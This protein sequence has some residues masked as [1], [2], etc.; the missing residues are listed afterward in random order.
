MPCKHRPKIN[1]FR[2]MR[3][4]Y[5][6]INIRVADTKKN[7]ISTLVSNIWSRMLLITC[8]AILFINNVTEWK[9]IIVLSI[10]YLTLDFGEA[11][12]ST[13]YFVDYEPDD[14]EKDS[15]EQKSAASGEDSQKHESAAVDYA[16]QESN[17]QGE[18]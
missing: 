4:R 11:V 3:C 1:I 16:Q 14:D 15:R 5:C 6:G 7:R 12:I 13:L 8:T 10:I 18:P 2:P 17:R 9:E